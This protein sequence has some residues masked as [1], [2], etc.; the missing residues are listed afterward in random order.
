M[1]DVVTHE[2]KGAVGLI[3]L[4]NPP[5]NAASAALRQ[6]LASAVKTLDAD[7]SVKVIAIYAEGRTFVAGADI[8]E[9]GKAPQ[10][11]MLPE[12]CQQI[13]D[14]D[15]PVICVL[16]GTTLG[17][18]LELAMSTHARIGVPGLRLGLPEVN[19][20]L[21]PGAGGTQRTPRLVGMANALDIMISGRQV[22]AA[23]AH[24][25]GLLEA[26]RDGAPRDLALAAAQEVLDG[27][28][29]TRRTG[30]LTVAPD[31]AL[32]DSWRSRLA[33]QSRHLL[34]PQKMVDLVGLSSGDL[35]Q[36]IA[37]ERH[38]FK[39]LLGTDQSKG[40]IHA[41]FAER[42]VQKV[43]EA[44]H[45]P[46][47]VQ[48]IGIIG[49]GTMGSGIA[50]ACLLAGL[51]VT[52]TETSDE[53]ADKA[54]ATIL[55]NLDGAVKRGKLR[56]DKRAAAEAGLT[57]ATSLDALSEADLII[58]AVFE[59]MDVKKAIFRELDR[60]AKSGAVLASNTSYLDI[61][62]IA[63]ETSRPQD[64]LG[65]H[66]FSPAHIMRLLEVIVAEKT[67]PEVAAT[68]FALGKRLRKVAVRAGV[69]DGFIGNRILGHYL[70]EADYLMMDGASP[71]Q[72]DTALE[73][74]GFAMGPF[75]VGDLAGLDIGWA[76]RKR[77]RQD[78]PAAERQY[79]TV[80]DRICEQGW[81]GRK[82]GQGF[83]LY[84]QKPPVPNPEVKAM[85]D[86]ERADEGVTPR[87]ISNEDIVDRY[88]TAMILEA[89]RVV[90]DGIA[91]RP[92]DVDAV[93]LFGYG[94]PRFR[95]GPLHYAD[96]LGAAEIV[97]R[98]ER[99]GQVDAHY[100]Q[101]PDLLR[102]MAAEGRSFNDM[103]KG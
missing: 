24:E 54:R 30:D 82:T 31:D 67:A 55:G 7:P 47:D 90:E 64:V 22:P 42:A 81:F 40:M 1:S 93:F 76:T 57:T 20:G 59:E 92:V 21:L 102:K 19:L 61:N 4:N 43:P 39:D 15:T 80:S 38:V 37:E 77:R 51:P 87:E 94:F 50:T 33:A 6:G 71:W 16:H 34:A 98:A 12:V 88:M 23:E 84:D 74:W 9:F 29:Q 72:I 41:F 100:W 65:L 91:L 97:R 70:K 18:G 25:M 75:A 62:E 2:I 79:G 68:G 86:A 44:T 89:A 58:E 63:A 60:I 10:N 95:G 73:D 52:L 56:A 3:A 11:P 78:A 35:T 101:V 36:G 17:G 46:R 69:C 28:L 66:F 85:I 8:T 49:G 26:I 96:T 27:T 103:N 45:T 5:V 13:E 48:S 53:G 32:L 83:Y 14:C 99:Y